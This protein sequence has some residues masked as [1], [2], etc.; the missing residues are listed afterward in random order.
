MAKK[1]SDLDATTSLGNGDLLALAQ[2]DGDAAT[3]YTSKKIIGANVAKAI[4][5]DFEYPTALPS[6]EDQTITGGMEELKAE[7]NDV[8]SNLIKTTGTENEQPYQL[9]Q[10]PTNIGNLCLEK[11][12]GVSCAFNQLVN[13]GDTSINTTSGK[14]YLTKIN[15]VWSIISGGSAV[16]IVDD[17][18][19][20]V[21]DLTQMFGSEV[22]DYL[23]SLENG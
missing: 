21:I 17:S 16:T 11:L 5:S 20:M 6:F 8:L 7:T 3:G 13:T 14:K 1:F 2:V 12:V 9:R 4:V 10:T 15:S 18:S 19:D 23:Y 22:A